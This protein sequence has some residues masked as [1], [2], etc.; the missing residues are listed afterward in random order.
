MRK[1]K[2]LIILFLLFLIFCSLSLYRHKDIEPNTFRTE[3]WADRAGYYVYLPSIFLYNFSGDEFP[4]NIEEQTGY[5]FQVNQN[6]DKVSTKYTYGVALLQLPFFLIADFISSISDNTPR[7]GFSFYYQKSI[8]FAAVFYLIIG[9]YLLFLTLKIYFTYSNK[10][11]LIT[12]LLLFFGTNLYYYSIVETGMSH[13]YSFFLFSGA[14]YLVTHKANFKNKYLFYILLAFTSWLIILIRPTNM[15]FVIIAFFWDAI[16]VKQILLRVKEHISPKIFSIWVLSGFII[17]IPQFIYWKYSTGHYLTYTYT[18]EGFVNALSP[19]LLE[20][21]FSPNNGLFP[22]SLIF[23]LALFGLILSLRNRTTIGMYSSIVFVLVTYLTASWH[24]WRFGCGSG[25]RNMVEYYSLFSFPICYS[26]NKINLVN[27]KLIKIA[28]Y[29]LIGLLAIISFKV[30]Y[31][32]YGCYFV[33]VW[34]WSE[35]IKTL[36]YPMSY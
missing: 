34:D 35:Y 28:F 17:F 23:I 25:M 24:D 33:D 5:G 31:H 7:D 20:V 18:N 4:E 8:N 1:S 16:S 6:N 22:Y 15:I 32:Y 11:I 10:T 19:K 21:L 3:I 26:I 2:R 14:L 12:L 27:K 36:I 9:L 13:I 29:A 30:N